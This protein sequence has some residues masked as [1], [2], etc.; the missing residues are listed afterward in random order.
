MTLCVAGVRRGHS[1][2]TP[3][4]GAAGGVGDVHAV[5]KELGRFLVAFAFGLDAFG[6]DRHAE[7]R[8]R[9][10][11]KGH[12]GHARYHRKKQQYGRNS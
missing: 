2:V 6:H 9:E 1:G 5:A 11:Q 7:E 10:H 3:D 12:R 8:G 4:G